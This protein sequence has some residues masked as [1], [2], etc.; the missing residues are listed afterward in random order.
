MAP[1]NARPNC[2]H[3]AKAPY[4]MVFDAEV[5]WTPEG[6]LELFEEKR[7]LTHVDKL[8]PEQKVRLGEINAQID[9]LEERR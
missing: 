1:F 4:G 7:L 9:E 5:E 3:A 2:E 6:L 8:S